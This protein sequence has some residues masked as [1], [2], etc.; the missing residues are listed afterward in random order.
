MRERYGLQPGLRQVGAQLKDP[1]V[2]KGALLHGDLLGAG[3][4]PVRRLHQRSPPPL[5]SFTT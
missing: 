5:H 3:H 2:N 4:L 1:V